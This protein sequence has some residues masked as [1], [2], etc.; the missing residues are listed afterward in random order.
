M[1]LLRPDG[2]GVRTA[3]R[4]LRCTRGVSSVELALF[5]PFLFFAI[6]AT[7]DLGLAAYERMT[8]DRLLRGGAQAAMSDPGAA[9]VRAVIVASA[10]SEFA[11]DTEFDLTVTRFCACPIA[12]DTAVPCTSAC[13]DGQAARVFYR[14]AAEREYPSTIIPA[15]DLAAN[16]RVQVR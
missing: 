9:H 1:I 13:T 14:L 3:A 12:P 4:M 2:P 15:L 7:L 16:A 5:A 8:M 11:P 10:E 6:A